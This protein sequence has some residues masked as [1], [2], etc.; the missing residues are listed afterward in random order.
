MLFCH[1]VAISCGT[2]D[3]RLVAQRGQVVND[4]GSSIWQVEHVVDF[5]ATA[6]AD[7]QRPNTWAKALS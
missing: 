6:I 1:D 5:G 2:G 3:G 7:S 4:V